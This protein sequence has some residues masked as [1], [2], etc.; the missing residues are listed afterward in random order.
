[1]TKRFF[2]VSLFLSLLPLLFSSC[3]DSLV[4]SKEAER[5]EGLLNQAKLKNDDSIDY[6]IWN[7]SSCAGCRSFSIRLLM[8]HNNSLR[9][10]TFIVP[11]SYADETKNIKNE[12]LYID[13]ANIFDEFYFG[14]DNVG[15]IKVGKQGVYSLKNYNANAMDSLEHDFINR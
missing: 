3:K 9:P 6:V 14:I 1:M 2:I 10:V 13:S 11:F 8:Q 12:Q 5:F 7:G 4:K 15:I